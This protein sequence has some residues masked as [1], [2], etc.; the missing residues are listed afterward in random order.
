MFTKS[1]KNN[2]TYCAHIPA[3]PYK[4]IFQEKEKSDAYSSIKWIKVF[5]SLCSGEPF[6]NDKKISVI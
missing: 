2:L 4:N 1:L 3:V 5:G 6:G